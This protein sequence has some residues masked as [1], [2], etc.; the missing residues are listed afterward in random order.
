MTIPFQPEAR[1]P[2]HGVRVIDLTR[3]VAGNMLS[4]LLADFGAEVI[5]VEVP[6]RGDTLRDWYEEGVPVFW[7]VYARN[8]QS[9]TLDIRK[10]EGRAVLEKLA[11]SSQ[12]LLESFRPGVLERLKLGPAEL[13]A[14]NP[15]LVMGRISGWGQT[16]PYKDRPGFGSLVE[17]MSGFAA[18]NGFSDKPPALPNMPL[19]DMAAGMSGAFAIMVALREAEKSGRGQV[20][21]I[22]LLEPLLAAIGPD[23]AEFRVSGKVKGRSGNRASITAPRNV[24]K[25][26]D[27]RFVALSAS[28]EDMAARLF[29][30][31]GRQDML[32][33]P[34]FRTNADRLQHVDA[35]DG[36]IQDFIGARDRDDLLA[37]FAKAEVTVG[38]VYDASEILED[39]HIKGRGVIIDLPDDDIGAIPMHAVFPRLSV[40]PGSIRHRA[41]KLG[42]QTD[43]I[44]HSLGYDKVGVADLQKKGVL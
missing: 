43:T 38:P 33:D 28:T 44:L 35:V 20:V 2:L 42:E 18:K 8:K 5:K 39:P 32:S 22:S 34:R 1:G 7:K 16:G 40:T 17:G 27:C 37:F 11:G 29:A 6:G 13:H 24:Y 26:R 31:I 3:L 25:T 30:A 21:D 4:L 10:P 15:A 19:A 14:A 12:I 9:I 36:A 23:A 41:P